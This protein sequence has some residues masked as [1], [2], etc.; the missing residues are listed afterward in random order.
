MRVGL[1]SDTHGRPLPPDITKVF[2]GVAHILH[3]GDVIDHRTLDALKQIAPVSAVGGNIDPPG[4]LPEQLILTFGETRVG[5]VH[6]H[7]GK[8]RTTPDRALRT[9][10]DEHVQVVVFGHSHMP[11]IERR[12]AVLLVNPGSATDPRSAPYPSVGVLTIG[13]TID[14][15]IVP[16]PRP[17]PPTQRLYSL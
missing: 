1:I 12:G 7:Y 17:L 3:A 14:A 5:L 9:F 13:Q 15:E 6:G 11:L 16:L 10:E 4:V 8:G 2:A